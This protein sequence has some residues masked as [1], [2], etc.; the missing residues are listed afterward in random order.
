MPRLC[1]RVDRVRQMS[2]A[3]RRVLLACGPLLALVAG[4]L[5]RDLPP[6]PDAGWPIPVHL[7]SSPDR[8]AVR[9]GGSSSIQFRLRDETGVAVPSHAVRFS[10]Q[11]ES[12]GRGT[13]GAAL[14]FEQSLTDENGNTTLQV[15]AGP[16]TA[17]SMP[18]LFTLHAA[19]LDVSLDV[20]VSVTDRPQSAAVIV[21]VLSAVADQAITSL[22]V[23]FYD[24]SSC[25][26]LSLHDPPK[27]QRSSPVLSP[28]QTLTVY[29]IAT[30]GS[31]AVLV[32]GETLDGTVVAAR[33]VDLLGADLLGT[34]TMRV[35]VRLQ[36]LYP[37][38]VGSYEVDSTFEFGNLHG[39]A[40]LRSAWQ[41]LSTCGALDPARLWLDCTFAALASSPAAPTNCDPPA[42]L[43]DPLGQALLSRRGVATSATCRGPQDS[44]GRPSLEATVDALFPSPRPRLLSELAALPDEAVALVDGLK[45]KSTLDVKPAAQGDGFTATH[46]LES[47]QLFQGSIHMPAI[48]V[49]E[50]AAPSARAEGI[51]ASYANG[52]LYIQTTHGFTLRLGTAVRHTFARASLGLRGGPADVY[53]F[54]QHL[55]DPATSTQ[56]G[57]TLHG[58]EA[59]DA[60]LCD[61]INALRGCVLSACQAGLKALGKSLESSFSALEG[62]GLD[63]FLT[64]G[65]SAPIIDRDGDGVADAL[66]S[67]LLNQ[68]SI[69]PSGPGLWSAELRSRSGTDAAFGSWTAQRVP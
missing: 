28:G 43:A 11:G 37:D 62:D 61:Q 24:S 23:D 7:E 68:L 2:S 4:C 9:P 58:C 8:L 64:T 65:S 54:A 10:L 34:G 57:S 6:L 19:A 29:S 46:T 51:Q 22:R 20:V 31:H 67:T 12:E 26:G 39:L 13:G 56:G 25:S 44:A 16:A 38:P 33:C 14:S 5:D 18:L 42:A 59:L 32:Q 60:V 35:P 45:I 30:D 17:A 50:L 15:I 52:Q 21:P 53:A 48:S 41:T 69:T 36:P 49:V 1:Y 66:G 55:F 63:F 27:P 40:Q 3:E 47:L